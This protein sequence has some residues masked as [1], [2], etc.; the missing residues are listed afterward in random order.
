MNMHHSSRWMVDE[1]MVSLQ[2]EIWVD[3]TG[4]RRMEK[5]RVCRIRAGSGRRHYSSGGEQIQHFLRRLKCLYRNVVVGFLI[6]VAVV[7]DFLSRLF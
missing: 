1:S 3:S 4:K 7:T 6:F 5:R 2:K